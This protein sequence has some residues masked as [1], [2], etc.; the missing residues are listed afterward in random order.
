MT[1]CLLWR[2]CPTLPASFNWGSGCPSKKSAAYPAVFTGIG[3]AAFFREGMVRA[4][5]H[6]GPRLTALKVA[7]SALVEP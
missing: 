6:E 1:P 3:I 4:L 5:R 2:R 7:V